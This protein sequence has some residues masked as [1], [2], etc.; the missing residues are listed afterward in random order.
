MN[1]TQRIFHLLN[2]QNKK[3][4]ELAEYVGISRSAISDWKSKGTTPT[5]EFLVKIC[6]F[7][8]VS[9]DYLLTGQERSGTSVHVGGSVSGGSVVQGNHSSVVIRNG[10]ERVLSDDAAELLRIYDSLNVK[11]RHKVLDMVF[12]LEENKN[13]EQ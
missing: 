11:N 5:A 13:N 2:I 4:S 9:L 10:K 3:Q 8:N 7:L 6:E 12:K 1:I